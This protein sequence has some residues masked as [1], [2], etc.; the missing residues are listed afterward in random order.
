MRETHNLRRRQVPVTTEI[1][2]SQA[3]STT[4]AGNSNAVQCHIRVACMKGNQLNDDLRDLPSHP[5]RSHHC[6][7]SH[8]HR[9]CR[10]RCHHCRRCWR[11]N[12][13][14]SSCPSASTVLPS[15]D[16]RQT[17]HGRSTCCKLDR[18]SA[19]HHPGA[20]SPARTPFTP[21]SGSMLQPG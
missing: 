18:G 15:Q 20:P 21:L 19:T 14:P 4:A 17:I 9:C 8:C 5:C 2:S 7:R 16:S 12:F 11:K 1:P 13:G 3:E 6:G 10:F